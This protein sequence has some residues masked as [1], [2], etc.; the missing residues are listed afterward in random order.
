[1]RWCLRSAFSF[2]TIE[3]RNIPSDLWCGREQWK[4]KSGG[5][6]LC[7]H[8]F[9]KSKPNF[10]QQSVLLWAG[11]VEF[12][13]VAQSCL[14]LGDPMDCSTSAFP[15]HHQLQGVLGHRKGSSFECLP[16][17][18][19]SWAQRTRFNIP[20]RCVSAGNSQN[21]DSKTEVNEAFLQAPVT[22][23]CEESLQPS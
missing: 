21:C 15:V 4:G 11:G 17:F 1:M 14:T 22:T 20:F 2:L 10:N 19:I 18:F 13:S 12:S 8:N 3:M 7:Q 6:A 5:Q 9:R 16:S 23:G